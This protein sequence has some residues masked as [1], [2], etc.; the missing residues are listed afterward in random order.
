MIATASPTAL[1]VVPAAANGAYWQW[2]GYRVHYVQAGSATAIS[3]VTDKLDHSNKL[4]NPNNPEILTEPARNQRPPL[5][6]IHGFGASTD[7]WRKNIAELQADFEVYALDLV[8]FGRSSKPSSGYS[9]ALWR[10]QIA[11]FITDVIGRPAVVVGN[12]IGGYSSLFAGATRSDAVVG[13][14]MLNGVGSFSEQ[15]TESTQNPFQ[16]AIAQLIK[17]VV[18]SPVPS[19]VIF[20]FVRNRAYIRKTLEQVYVN[21]SEVT[22]QLIEDIYR[23]A[24]DPEAPAAFAALFKAE[25]GEY[26]DTLLS[27]MRCPLLLIWG[28]ADPWMDTYARGALFQKHYTALEE[29]HL[30]AGHCPHDDAPT[31][32]NA[33][34]RHWVL[35]TVAGESG[36]VADSSSHSPSQWVSLG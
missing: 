14:G 11:E 13:V 9:S 10:D 5:L 7:H 30:N 31:E 4:D 17:T 3:E 20:Q 8:G 25:R 26:V 19:W 27:Q 36:R 34:I 23:P 29:H 21:K 33:L 35:T 2:R 22:D 28:D 15:Q 1:P 24:T 6:F 12:S 18:L 32:V 16:A